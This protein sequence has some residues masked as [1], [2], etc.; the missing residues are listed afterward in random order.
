MASLLE[1]GSYTLKQA[2]SCATSLY[3]QQT[4]AADNNKHSIDTV[5]VAHLE[6]ELGCHNIAGCMYLQGNSKIA[7]HMA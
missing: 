4:I 2:S 1:D 6:Q 5:L 7:L 3:R